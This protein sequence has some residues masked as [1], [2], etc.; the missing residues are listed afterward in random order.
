MMNRKAKEEWDFIIIGGGICGLSLGAL[1]ANDGYKILILEKANEIGG[2]A[3][4]VEKNGFTLDYGIHTVRFGKKSALAKTLE[5]IRAS[6]QD[7]ILF[8]ELGTS[9]FF[10]EGAERSRWTVFPTGISGITKGDYFSIWKLKNV[11]FKLMMARKKRNL[12]VSVNE[13]QVK[14]NLNEEG[15]RYLKSITGSMQV[16]PFLERASMGE[17]RRNLAEVATKRIS[18]AYPI[19][20]WKL[21]FKRLTEKIKENGNILTN[22][23]VDKILIENNLAKGVISG[24]KKFFSKNII[25]A[26]PVQEIFDFLNENKTNQE[27]V[28]QC[29]KLRPTA[30]LSI[31]FALKKKISED[32]GLFYLENIVDDLIAFG[33]FT[34]NI[35]EECVPKGKQLLTFC[36]PCNVEDLEN[37]EFREEILTRLKEKLFYAF[38]ELEEN[39]EFERPLFTIFDGVEVNINQYQELRPKFKVPGIHNIYLV[40]DSTAGK[41]AGGDIGHNSVW[42]TY[43]IIREEK[44]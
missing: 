27:F 29:K 35:D 3:K 43:E 14:K 21:I 8:K 13:W 40:G 4:V 23:M 10:L 24:E 33:F 9:Y 5:T 17:L 6:D 42:N 15:Q 31:D 36:C 39:I 18:V 11:L 38:L 12:D 19:G 20:G 32:R 44:R 2:R 16:C 34:S 22:K 30:G 37:P 1:L 26:I 41:G 25:I 7:P 28:E